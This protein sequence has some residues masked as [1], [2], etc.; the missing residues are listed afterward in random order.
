MS[1]S[2]R[3]FLGVVAG[4]GVGAM[5]PWK[6]GHAAEAVVEAAEAGAAAAPVVPVAS[7]ILAKFTPGGN[8]L[9]AHPGPGQ[10]GIKPPFVRPALELNQTIELAMHQGAYQMHPQLPNPTPTWGYGSMPILGPTIE[11]RVLEPFTVKWTN[12]LPGTHLLADAIDP[13]VMGADPA[14]YPP[15]RAVTHVHGGH[16]PHTVDGGPLAWYTNPF[17]EPLDPNGQPY[18]ANPNSYGDT[19]FYPM[20]QKRACSIWYHDHALGITRLNVYAGL[21][22][23]FN[24]RDAEEDAMNLPSGEYEIP[25]AIQDRTFNAD[26]SL[27][28]PPGAPPL[29]A[30]VPEFFGDTIIVNGKVWPKLVVQ[31]RKYRFRLL[32]GCTSRFLRMQLLPSDAIGGVAAGSAPLTFQQIGTEGGF[33]DAP[34]PM[35][36]LTMG[37]GERCDV[38]IDFATIFGAKQKKTRYCLLYNDAGTPF[39][40]TNNRTGAIPEIMLF[41]IEPFAGTD[42]FGTLPPPPVGTTRVQPLLEANAVLPYRNV[43][44][45]EVIDANGNLM[46]VLDGRAFQD[47]T[48]TETPKLGDTEVWNIIN[49]T[50]DTHPIH[51]HQTMFQILDRRTFNPNAY[52][53]AWGGATIPAPPTI[54]PTPFFSGQ[55]IA[56]DPNELGWKDTIRANP[57]QVTRIIIKWEDLAGDYVWHCHILEHEDH[58]MMRPLKILP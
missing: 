4:A 37:P 46:A 33:F 26:G 45:S 49:L 35:Q 42:P 22:A 38:I 28:Y 25:L 19:Y 32:N 27:Y 55:P 57:G 1:T 51:L 41:Q 48:I 8:V 21:A 12:S 10:A 14:M 50:P 5:V 47:G 9:Y 13:R 58:D 18:A 34:V 52:M 54:D 43:T 36:V 3:E 40:N 39:A 53:K 31:A 20:D 17:T 16:V 24:V 23:F 30:H 2:R 6:V 11:A 15:V 56:P 44:L 29:G 7:P